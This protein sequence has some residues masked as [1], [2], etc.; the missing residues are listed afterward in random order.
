M[1]LKTRLTDRF[2]IEHP[3][4]LA[5]MDNV[6]DACL[7]SAVSAAGGL[8]LL[9]G[10][11]ADQ[12]WIRDQ[13]D[14]VTAA[15]GCGFITWTLKGNE[16]ALDHAL[17]R[18]PAAIFLSFGDPAPYAPRIRAA[19][20]PLI[21][22][23]HNVRQALRAVEVGADV[24]AAQGGEAGG[25]GEGQRSTFTLVPEI[26]DLVAST[27]PQVLV[28]AAGGVTDGRGLA[29]SLALGADGVL[30]GTRFWAAHEAAISPAAQQYALRVNGDMTIRQHVYDIVRG[31]SWPRTY[32]GRVLRNDFV[33][34]WHDHENE[35]VAHLDQARSGYEIGVTAEDYRVANLIVGEGIGRIR[36]IETAADIVHSMVIQAA[37]ISPT[38][39][40][41]NTC[42]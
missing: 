23:V 10:G 28:L 27:A 17:E 2:G 36:Q 40:G 22:Q 35:L 8:G 21:C 19:G 9:G 3:V 38:H 18:N 6:A 39:Q 1:T 7:A 34:T 11:Y 24:I 32:S 5:P 16:Q 29:A 20:V 33:D 37:A 31:K 12:T 41:V 30:V 25:H 4:V 15:V 14:R 26:A 42:H 13:F